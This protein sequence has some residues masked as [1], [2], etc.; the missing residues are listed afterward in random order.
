MD[1]EGNPYGDEMEE[2]MGIIDDGMDEP[3][4]GN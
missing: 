3:N 1:E 2:E 4:M